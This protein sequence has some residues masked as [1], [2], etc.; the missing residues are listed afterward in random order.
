MTHSPGTEKPVPDWILTLISLF[1]I[2]DMY[3][4][5]PIKTPKSIGLP[6]QFS[7]D[8]KPE[9]QGM[10]GSGWFM[11]ARLSLSIQKNTYTEDIRFMLRIDQS[12]VFYGMLAWYL[13]SSNLANPYGVVVTKNDNIDGEEN[14]YSITIAMGLPYPIQYFKGINVAITCQQL[15]LRDIN[16]PYLDL[17]VSPNEKSFSPKNLYQDL[18]PHWSY[19]EKENELC[20]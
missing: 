5:Q 19:L 2:T 12:L 20:A 1:N 16:S 14:K 9:Y 17:L 7:L 13:N 15:S 4:F 6:I 3:K 11:A 8:T 18:P 10:S